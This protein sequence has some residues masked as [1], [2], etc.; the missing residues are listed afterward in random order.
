MQMNHHTPPLSSQPLADLK[1]PGTLE[2]GKV[3]DWQGMGQESWWGGIHFQCQLI[4][5]KSVYDLSGV[6]RRER[7]E[8]VQTC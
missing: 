6:K 7:R 2:T 8:M 5:G 3:S 1:G 4:R